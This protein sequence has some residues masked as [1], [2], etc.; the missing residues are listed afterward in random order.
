MLFL[1]IVH[2]CNKV[3]F[4]KSPFIMS[5]VSTICVTAIAIAVIISLTMLYPTF[6]KRNIV[7]KCHTLADTSA[8]KG[9]GIDSLLANKKDNNVLPLGYTP[10]YKTVFGDCM[11]KKGYR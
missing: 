11:R 9:S 3:L 4:M 1:Q 7:S 10:K 2:V 6:H 8:R 5:R